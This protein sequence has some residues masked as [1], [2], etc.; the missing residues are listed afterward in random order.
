MNTADLVEDFI[1]AFKEIANP[2]YI[3]IKYMASEGS[4]NLSKDGCSRIL[5]RSQGYYCIHHGNSRKFPRNTIY[6]YTD[7]YR[8]EIGIARS[9][10]WCEAICRFSLAD[11]DCYYK[12]MDNLFFNVEEHCEEHC[13]KIRSELWVKPK[14]S[15]IALVKAKSKD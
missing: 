15:I 1:N 7:T 12:L 10:N 4:F 6:V 8:N 3:N 9:S 5:A 2:L 11:P 13:S 14:D